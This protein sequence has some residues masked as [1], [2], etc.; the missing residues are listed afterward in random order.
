MLLR[1]HCRKFPTLELYPVFSL[2]YV[3]IYMFI[4]IYI[5]IHIHIHNDI[6]RHEHEQELMKA[7]RVMDMLIYYDVDR[8]YLIH[9]VYEVLMILVEPSYHN[10]ILFLFHDM[11][12]GISLDRFSF[13]AQMELDTLVYCPQGTPKSSSKKI[14]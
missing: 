5:H 12:Y 3:Y 7:H 6:H 8:N 2:T 14:F 1:G 13:H 10:N 11:F 4:Y 9:F